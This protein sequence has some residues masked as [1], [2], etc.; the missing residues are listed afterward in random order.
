MR[1]SLTGIGRYTYELAKGLRDSGSLEDVRFQFLHGW[2]DDPDELIQR[3]HAQSKLPVASSSKFTEVGYSM[4]RSAYRLTSP[5]LQGVVSLPYMD[6]IFHSPNFVLPYFPGKRVSTIHDMSAFRVP[7]YH[8]AS[9]VKYQQSIFPHL[10][11]NGSLFITVSE[12][13]KSEFLEFFPVPEDR[14]VSILEGADPAFKPRSESE[15]SSVLSR[16]GLSY[17][18]YSLCVGTIEPRKNVERLI[19][20]YEKLSP[21]TRSTW[22]LV[23]VGGRGW[24]SEHIHEKIF[25]YSEAGWLKYLSFVDDLELPLLYSGAKLFVFLSLYEGFG[26]PVLEAMASGIPVLSSNVSSL[27]E[28]GGDAVVYVSPTDDEQIIETIGRLLINDEYLQSL[29]QRGI[30]RSMEFSWARAAHETI[31]AY[32]RIV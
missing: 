26:L 31:D 3:Y 1:V 13:S 19:D 32:R 27:P 30:Q 17:G 14:V 23:L 12:F 11:K 6:Y 15:V 9:R 16:Y 10:V 29:S 28:V 24:N 4:L 18:K 7:Q 22:P 25:R 8:P 20:A 2:V 21:Q 5:L